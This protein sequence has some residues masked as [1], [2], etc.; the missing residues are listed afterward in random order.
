MLQCLE[1]AKGDI[2]LKLCPIDHHNVRA[3]SCQ[4]FPQFDSHIAENYC[5]LV[6]IHCN[7]ADEK[8]LVTRQVA[9]TE[10]FE[11]NTISTY[12]LLKGGGPTTAW[13][14]ATAGVTEVAVGERGA[15][16]GIHSPSS[17]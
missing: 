7:Q 4:A 12:C 14:L 5:V 6:A 1:Q 10:P 16:R 9:P 11:C 3:T 2:Y 15:H 13:E 8:G 17:A